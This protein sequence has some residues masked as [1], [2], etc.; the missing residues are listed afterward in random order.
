M[1][2]E[3]KVL[4]P[5]IARSRLLDYMELSKPELTG[6]SVFTALCGFYLA[7]S[8]SFD[9]VLFLHTAVGTALVG[10]GA[11]ALNQYLE[12]HHDGL[13][14][15]TEKRPLPSGRLLPAEV[16]LFGMLLSIVGIAE[17]TVFANALTGFLAALTFA[18]YLF[19]YTPLK[20]ITP[21]ATLL[22]AVPGALPPL[23][24]WTA[25]RNEVT[26]EAW[27]LFAVL[28][29]WQMP[30]FLS[31]AWMYRRDYGK[32]GFKVLTVFDPDGRRTSRQILV[33][34]AA[35]I[36][37]SLIPPLIGMTGLISFIGAVLLGGTFLGFGIAMWRYS[38]EMSGEGLARIN[39]CSRK[40]FYASLIY[41]PAILLLF[42]LDKV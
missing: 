15:R 28:F 37:A 10:G 38:G 35:L 5:V 26:I 12:R 21:F 4:D 16:L 19:L 29:C 2:G 13:M 30:H 6:L 33:F 42:L 41:L 25:V 40:L 11:G 7:G 36:L 22:G 20:R 39:S 24:G 9:F 32:A 8:G 31:L 3:A 34:T 27:V 23:I 1:N 14:K 17:L 18:T